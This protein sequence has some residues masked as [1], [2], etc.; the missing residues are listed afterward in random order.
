MKDNSLFTKVK[1]TAINVGIVVTALGAGALCM[2]S[3]FDAGKGIVDS[4]ETIGKLGKHAISP[5]P[6]LVKEKGLFGKTRTVTINPVTGKM[7]EYNGS[8]AP[9]NS[10]PIKLK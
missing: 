6:V 3:G 5:D 10:K 4:A 7:V 2:Q 8:K 1:D 9:V